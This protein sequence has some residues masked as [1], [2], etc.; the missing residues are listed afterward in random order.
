MKDR[1]RG[2]DEKGRKG[3]KGKV[4]EAEVGVGFIHGA[5]GSAGWSGVKA[6]VWGGRSR[7]IHVRE[8]R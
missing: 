3:G 7:Y 1:R 2:G 6:E 8:R 5:V 4:T